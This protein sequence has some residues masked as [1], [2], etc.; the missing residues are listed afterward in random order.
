MLSFSMTVKPFTFGKENGAY[1]VR[2]LL[3]FATKGEIGLFK[4]GDELAGLRGTSVIRCC[5]RFFMGNSLS[6]SE[7]PAHPICRCSAAIHER[8]VLNR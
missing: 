1:E 5:D 4:K 6:D 3:P 7:G 8:S 2:M